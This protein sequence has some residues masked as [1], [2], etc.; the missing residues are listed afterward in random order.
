MK[1]KLLQC[2]ELLQGKAVTCAI[3]GGADSVALLHGLWSVR[4]ELEL[5]L[6]A[7]HFHHGLR[8]TADR[9]REFV[10]ALC[11]KLEIPL[12]LGAADVK[13]YA[14]THGMS[15]EEAA[16]VLRYEFLMEQPGL[17][18]TAHNADDQVETV[19]INLL[20]GTGLKGLCAME[21][22]RGR[23]VRPLLDVSRQ[24]IERYLA[25]NGLAH[26][27]DESNFADD[28]LRNRL[29]HHVVPLLKEENPDL[30]RTISRMTELLQQD[31]AYLQT[32]TR[33]LLER[34]KA[35]GGYDCR[36]LRQ[37]PLCARA[38]RSLLQI[39]KPSMAHVQ[40]VCSLMEDLD[41]TKQVQLPH[42][43][44]VRQY[45]IIYFGKDPCGAVPPTQIIDLGEAGSTLWGSWQI[46]WQKEA[47]GQEIKTLCIRS[48]LEGD[49]VRLPGGT[50]TVKKLLIDRK[51]PA[52]RR[53]HL[54]IL[55]HEDRVLA[56]ADLVQA[57][58]III[59]ERKL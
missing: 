36:V 53:D 41:G 10:Q 27:D 46:S 12:A 37:D 4:Q 33:E 31:E 9:D 25:Q 35:D 43:R 7:A 18:A 39:P 14:K 44:V 13:A 19:L 17:I 40:A 32:K 23:L 50:K 1:A 47:C 42:M 30:T 29:R 22:C 6:S 16:R 28:A 3:S 21:R 45:H 54:P 8:E 55:V 48:R 52:E 15:V 5:K 20:R 49:C 26:C 56:V 57:R 59:E 58:G 24:Q 34:A 38:V 11:A 2:R 51:I